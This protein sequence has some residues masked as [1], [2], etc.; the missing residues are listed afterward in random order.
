MSAGEDIRKERIKKLEK[1][2]E[3]K[4]NPYPAKI[5]FVLT[6]IL[7]SVSLVLSTM[8]LTPLY[9][10]QGAV[11]AFALNYLLHWFVMYFMTK[12]EFAIL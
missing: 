11:I 10:L 1:L 9:G 12:R 7:F 6:E 8:F 4:I 3:N 5:A 2:A